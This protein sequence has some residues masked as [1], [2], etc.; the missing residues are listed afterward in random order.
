MENLPSKLPRDIATK[1]ALNDAAALAG[2]V[3]DEFRSTYAGTEPDVYLRVLRSYV[4]DF[5]GTLEA[6]EGRVIAAFGDRRIRIR[7]G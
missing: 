6:R 4:A 1:A 2:M 3:A 5:E 7:F